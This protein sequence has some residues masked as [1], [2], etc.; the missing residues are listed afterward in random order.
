MTSAPDALAGRRNAPDKTAGKVRQPCATQPD[1][2]RARQPEQL[3]S[4]HRDPT[5]TTAKPT[6]RARLT[7]QDFEKARAHPSG[8]PDGEGEKPVQFHDLL[9]SQPADRV[10]D[11]VCADGDETIR[12][13]L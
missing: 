13:D 3:G 8:E 7:A 9:I 2:N 10:A 11:A 6:V 12:L 4:A 1:A 5:S